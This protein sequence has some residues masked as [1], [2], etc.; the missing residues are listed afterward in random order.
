MYI[1]KMFFI[2]ARETAAAAQ[3]RI[4][5]NHVNACDKVCFINLPGI[6]H[7][8]K[9]LADTI[10]NA[11]LR[12]PASV[13]HD[14]IHFTD[15]TSSISLDRLQVTLSLAQTALLPR[16]VASPDVTAKNTH[17]P[18]PDGKMNRYLP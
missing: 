3:I 2:R 7:T 15:T 6:F 8:N 13:P 18:R 10:L 4:K 9:S 12:S 14:I 5:R 11:K 16:D 17:E 1:L